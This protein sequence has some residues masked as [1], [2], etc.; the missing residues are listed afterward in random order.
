MIIDI[1]SD[2]HLDYYFKNQSTIPSFT[3][4]TQIHLE[5][6]VLENYLSKTDYKNLKNIDITFNSVITHCGKRNPGDVLIIAGD[7]GHYNSQN[8]AII[9]ALKKLYYKNIICVLGNHD[10][11]LVGKEAKLQ[12]KDSLQRAKDL[13]DSLNEIDGVYCLDGNV[14]EING[15]RFG[16]CD[17]WYSSGF[18]NYNYPYSC[19]TKQSLNVMWDNCTPDKKGLVGVDNF[20]DIYNI[21]LPKI[22]AVYKKCDVMITHYNPSI[23]KEHQS[24]RFLP[25]PASTFFCFNGLRFMEEGNMKYWIFGH[26]HDNIEYDYKGVKCICNPMGYP[27]EN[28]NMEWVKTFDIRL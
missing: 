26:T 3:K 8:V 10:Y 18:I 5:D 16:G 4:R 15:V 19:E 21:E 23:L 14:I 27:N 28:G 22:E 11:Y 12:F 6:L 17:G 24:Q 2:L 25:N 9:K 20:D 7:I 13:R 1:L